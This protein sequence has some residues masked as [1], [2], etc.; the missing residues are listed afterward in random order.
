MRQDTGGEHEKEEYQGDDDDGPAA[1]EPPT[2]ATK[3]EEEDPGHSPD[4]RGFFNTWSKIR[5]HLREP[6]AEWLGVTVAMTL[7][8]CAGLSTYT[9]QSQAGSFASLAAAWGFGF[10]I[11]IYISGG[12]SGGHLNPAIT[13]SLC[14]WRGFPPRKCVVYILAQIVGAITAGGFAYAIYHDA[15]V[16]SAAMQQVSQGES[17]AA[18]ALLTMPKEFVKPAT[19]F[20]N[21]FLGSA[22]LV[23]AILA[24]GDDTNAPPGA[25]MQA[26]IVG[27]LITVL[28]MALGYNTGGSV[29]HT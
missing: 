10:M 16:S 1:Q 28:V 3:Y 24:L 21:E 22:I 26:F 25:G 27:I 4:E 9:S 8:L 12:V 13:I 7:G 19:A 20:F 23:G 29:L 11:A 17:Q 2:D 6:L 5:Y 15:I 18:Q 14:V